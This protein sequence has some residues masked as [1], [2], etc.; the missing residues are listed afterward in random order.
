MG[1]VTYIGKN[2]YLYLRNLGPESGRIFAR[3]INSDIFDEKFDF[4]ILTKM[5][6]NTPKHQLSAVLDGSRASFSTILV[7][8]AR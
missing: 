5:T 3:Q 7:K 8:F 2:L 1:R 6:Q 4:R